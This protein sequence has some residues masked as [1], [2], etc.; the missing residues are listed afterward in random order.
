MDEKQTGIDEYGIIGNLRTTA[1]ISKGG[2]LDFLCYPSFDSPSVFAKLVDDA[3]GG[4]FSI[5]VE[6]AQSVK[7]QY[8]ANTNVLGSR[9]LTKGRSVVVTDYMHHPGEGQALFPGVIRHVCATQGR[10][11]VK[12]ACFPAFDYGRA[13][14]STRMMEDVSYIGKDGRG[15]GRCVQFSSSKLSLVLHYVMKGDNPDWPQVKW[16]KQIRPGM[17]GEGVVSDVCLEE[18]QEVSFILTHGADAVMDA[19]LGFSMSHDQPTPDLVGVLLD[20]TL[21]FWRNWISKSSYRGRW[22]ENVARS[23]LALKLLTYEPTGAIVAAPTFGLPEEIGGVRNWDYRYSWIRDSSFTVYAFIR[24]GFTQ[25][26]QEYMAYVQRLLEKMNTDGSLSI[27][28]TV[29]GTSVPSELELGFQGHRSSKPV[30]IGNGAATH[31]Q[32]DVYGELLDGVYLI[33]KFV[34]PISFD[35]WVLVRRVVDYVCSNWMRPDMSIWEVRSHQQPF[36]YSKI[37]CWV[38][39]DRALRL[40]EKRMFPCPQRVLWLETR[41]AI[42]EKVMQCGWDPSSKVFTQSFDSADMLDASVLI[43][44]LVFFI[45][46]TDP[47]FLSTLDRI[48]MPL[49]KGGLMENNLIYRYNP[50]T[51]GIAGGEGS[52]S[53]CSFWLVEALTRAGAYRPHYLSIATSLFEQLLGYGSHLS[54]YSEQISSSGEQLGNFP[55]AFTHIALISAAFNL[56]RVLK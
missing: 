51:D 18:G 30:C 28:Y 8:L 52:F 6:D 14:H 7:Q 23:A 39:I 45:S 40:S 36:V 34:E 11:V 17:N 31:L 55:Q 24:L 44:P 56:D 13:K 5:S 32:L 35:L 42:Y 15:S 3:C 1:H 12:V 26:A 47:R 33:N 49:D 10:S 54:L 2:S 27:M 43:M 25:E 48:L 21:C 38:A 37:M 46:P 53:M 22:R 20:E 16:E 9:H 19:T 50:A 41:D 29:H 4:Y